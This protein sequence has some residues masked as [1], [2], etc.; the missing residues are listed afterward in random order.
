MESLFE[1]FNTELNIHR[2]FVSESLLS[3]LLHTSDLGDSLSFDSKYT[4]IAGGE[5]KIESEIFGKCPVLPLMPSAEP[6]N[7]HLRGPSASPSA[8]LSAA[9]SIQPSSDPCA[10]ANHDNFKIIVTPDSSNFADLY[11]FVLRRP[12]IGGV[13]DDGRV[14]FRKLKFSKSPN[15]MTE[16]CIWARQC[17]KA[18]LYSKSGNGIGNGSFEAY[19]QGTCN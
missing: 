11:V 9:P 17:L 16:K 15:Q 13:F 14:A 8:T 5:S 2:L 18:V 6:S 7:S 19:W 12:A 3:H 4:P 1:T 10:K